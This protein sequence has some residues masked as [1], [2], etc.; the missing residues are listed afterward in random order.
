M[1]PSPETVATN[2]NTEKLKNAEALGTITTLPELKEEI[3]DY[4]VPEG[5]IDDPNAF[6]L[7]IGRAQMDN[8]DYVEVSARLFKYITRGQK[9]P[10]L[11]Y[12]KPGVK[13]FIEGTRERLLKEELMNAEDHSNMMAKRRMASQG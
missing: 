3:F 10:Y 2:A 9:T 5:V 13:V 12:G 1:K 7:A 11:T 6:Q 8:L 4:K